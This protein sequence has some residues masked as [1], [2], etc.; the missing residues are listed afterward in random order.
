MD[1][2]RTY[3]GWGL[4]VSAI[5]LSP[6]VVIFLIPLTIGMGFDIF[7]LVGEAPFALALCVPAAFVLLRLVSAARRLRPLAAMRS[8]PQLPARLHYAPKSIN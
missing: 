2:V 1:N 7:D 6:I 8:R 3:T 4:L 5:L